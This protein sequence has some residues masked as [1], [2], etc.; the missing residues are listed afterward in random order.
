MRALGRPS[1]QRW[2]YCLIAAVVGAFTSGVAAGAEGVGSGWTAL[3]VVAGLTAGLSLW[4]RRTFP[5]RGLLITLVC[6]AINQIFTP[7]MLFPYAA[8]F[9][10]S[11][12]A[13]ARPPKVSLPGLLGVAGITA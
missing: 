11:S 6:C 10:L 7:E 5:V 8:L 3:N 2:V 13:A 12:V 4:W 9:A 1:R